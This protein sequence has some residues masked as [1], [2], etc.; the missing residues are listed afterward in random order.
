MLTIDI[1]KSHNKWRTH[2]CVGKPFVRSILSKTFA[3]FQ[4]F[5]SAQKI[6]VTI[7]LTD[8]DQMQTLNNQFLGKNKPTNVLSFPDEERNYKTILELRLENSYINL[9]DIA[10]G[11]EIIEEEANQQGKE[12]KHH[13]AH[14]LVH[15]L[16]HLLGFDH[17]TDEEAQ[18]M[19]AMEIEV[20]RELSIS[21]PY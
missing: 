20:L 19:H 7:L 18:V 5:R 11:Y 17:E 3:K 9:G 1:I 2:K 16:L 8:N 13:F 4:N 14:L 6:E 15:G 10:F 21:S 12:F